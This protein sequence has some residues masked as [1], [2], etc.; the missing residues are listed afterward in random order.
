MGSKGSEGS[1]GMGMRGRGTHVSKLHE[2]III[3]SILSPETACPGGLPP[4]LPLL[5]SLP[6]LS[7]REGYFPMTYP[8]AKGLD[9]TVKFVVSAGRGFVGVFRESRRMN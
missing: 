2:N 7:T 6:H 4:Y 9:I 1:E 8:T 5:P 3:G